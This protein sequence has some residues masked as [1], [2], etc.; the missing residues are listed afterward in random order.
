MSRRL[1]HIAFIF[2]LLLILNTP[3]AYGQCL[4][5]YPDVHVFS[6]GNPQSEVHISVNP[7]NPNNLILSCNTYTNGYGSQ[8]YFYSTDGGNTWTVIMTNDL[9][10]RKLF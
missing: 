7:A 10:T 1:L 9:I 6:S 3:L 8:G 4:Y 2:S 5:D